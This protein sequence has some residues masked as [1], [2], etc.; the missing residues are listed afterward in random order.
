VVVERLATSSL[1]RASAQCSAQVLTGPIYRAQVFDSGIRSIPVYRRHR[2]AAAGSRGRHSHSF[3]RRLLMGPQSTGT[4]AQW[5]WATAVGTML[6]GKAAVGPGPR[7]QQFERLSAVGV[8]HV[9]GLGEDL[10]AEQDVV[11]PI[12]RVVQL[13]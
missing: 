7:A 1:W 8:I 9:P 4:V 3:M 5:P 12:A 11:V 6:S 2:A 10:E 13:Q